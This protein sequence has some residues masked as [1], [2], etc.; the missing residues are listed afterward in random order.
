MGMYADMEQWTDIRQRA[1]AK[2]ESKRAILRETGM[3]WRTLEKI[4]THPEPPGYQQ[5]QSRNRPK[6]GPFESRI[7]QILKDDLQMPRKQRHTAQR[8]FERLRD[9]HGYDGCYSAVKEAVRRMRATCQ[10]VFVP[11]KHVP[12]EAQVD[13]GHALARVDGQ[14][15]KVP[16]FV[17]ALPHS[18]A[19]FV[20]AFERECT[21]T[22]WEGHVRAFEFFGAVPSR[23]SYDNSR[24]AV[25]K[26]MEGTERQLTQGFL[27]LQSHYLFEHHFCRAARGN[28]KGVVEGL[29]KY[30]RLN[31]MVPTPRVADFAQLNADLARCCTGDLKRRLRGK[32][33]TKAEL[34]VED[35][36]AMLAL[37][38][39]PF[40]A[41]RTISSRA[42]SLS[43]ARFDRNDYSVP[44]RW[45]H[46]PLVVKGYCWEVAL[47]AQG[48][49]VARHR[50]IWDKEQVCFEPRHYLALLE[51]KPGALD[52]ALPL[53]GW[54]LPACLGVLRRRLESAM[55]GSGV[56]E[57][58]RV[59]RLLEKHSMAALSEAVDKA[60]EH[61]AQSRDAIALF[62]YPPERHENQTFKLDG[63]PHLKGVRVNSPNI[64]DYAQLLGGSR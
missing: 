33:T 49:E 43:L 29:V 57:Y 18:D 32:P 14:L 2:G 22:F 48:R 45:A 41:A 63:H 3:H 50:R 31:F 42:N 17:M 23:I 5:A 51:R 38:P 47:C 44:V 37:P 6:I 13:F 61:G 53:D 30:S 21:E 8:I 54:E 39:A 59:L 64:G 15:R 52:Y 20:A 19:F 27:Q 56:R 62:L 35:R 36:A 55:G 46:H 40:E 58:I 1:L 26:I 10:E 11:L 16:F 25:S 12:G 34:L 28:E 7:E 24:I 60:M 4:L 9:E